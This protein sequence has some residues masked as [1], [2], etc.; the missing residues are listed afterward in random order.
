MNNRLRST[1][2]PRLLLTVGLAVGLLGGGSASATQADVLAID[3]PAATQDIA[4]NWASNPSPSTPTQFHLTF[5]PTTRS[6]YTQAAPLNLPCD[7]NQLAVGMFFHNVGSTA[8]YPE[9]SG[10][11]A[12]N[13]DEHN[14]IANV[15]NQTEPHAPENLLLQP[16]A[17]GSGGFIFMA[18]PPLYDFTPDQFPANVPLKLRMRVAGYSD[19]AYDPARGGFS[20]ANLVG[21]SVV[22]NNAWTVWVQRTC[23]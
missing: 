7:V 12:I 6:A 3:L 1:R 4:F 14:L 23:P 22:W 8:I 11:V 20:L 15:F 5:S 2:A 21:E 16:G 19:S 13:G 10:T 17:T 18:L 9:M